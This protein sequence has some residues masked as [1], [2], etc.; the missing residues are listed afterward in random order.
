MFQ[1][2]DRVLVL[3]N[4]RDSIYGDV[5]AR[6][7]LE[8]RGDPMKLEHSALCKGDW[9]NGPDRPVHCDNCAY[10]AG[11]EAGCATPMGDEQESALKDAI[12]DEVLRLGVIN[13]R[14]KGLCE[15]AERCVALAKFREGRAK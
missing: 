6:S 8:G 14:L 1:T 9:N 2:G 4:N 10:A 3:V 12:V 15:L 11:F 7:G 5:R 13:L